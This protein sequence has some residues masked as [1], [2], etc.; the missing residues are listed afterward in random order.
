MNG[1][2]RKFAPVTAAAALV[3]V[4][5]API[6][7]M[8]EAPERFELGTNSSGDACT[9]IRQW[10]IGEGI[11]RAGE[12]PF[13]IT[14]RG[15]SAAESQGYVS[16]PG[17]EIRADQCG[18][19]VTMALKGIGPVEVRRC[20]DAQLGQSAVDVRFKHRGVTYHG[21]ALEVALGPL[22][23]AIRVIAAGGEPPSG[24]GAAK[25]SILLADVPAGPAVS[26]AARATGITAE[27]ALADGIGAL[28]AGRMLDASRVLNDALRAFVDADVATKVDLRLAAGLADS[29]VS[30]FDAARGHF[31]IARQLLDDNPALVNASYKRQQLVT[32]QG[33]DLINQRHW[34]D[35]ID[36]LSKGGSSSRDLV[37]PMTL[38]RLN[39]ESAP[40][41]NS[42]QSS[43]TDAN[44][45]S[46][47]LLDA[48]GNWAISVAELALGHIPQSE[49]ALAR[50]ADSARDSVRFVAPERIVWMRAAIERQ[51]GRI[52]AR[53]GNLSASLANFDCAIAGLQGSRP[54]SEHCVF[55]EARRLTDAAANAPL[56]IE[57]QLERASI[58]S[59]DP[60][61]DRASVLADYGNAIQSLSNQTGIGSVSLGALERYFALLTQAPQGDSRDE[62]YFH[63]MQTIGEPAIAREYAQLQKVVSADAEVAGLLRQRG[64]LERQLIRLRYEI[65]AASGASS[66]D[67]ADLEAERA[68]AGTRLTD[69]NDKLLAANGIGALE[70]QPATIAS[71]RAAL[72]PGEV[73]LKLTALRSALFGIAISRD[74]TMIYQL[75]AGLGEIDKLAGAVLTSARTDDEGVLRPFDVASAQKLFEVVSGP[76]AEMLS[77]AAKLVYDPAGAL[78]QVPAAILVTDKA[79]VDAYAQQTIKSDYSVV[80]FLARRLEIA[81][82]LSP[83]AFLRGRQE[84]GAS[85]APLPFLG[86]G[87]NAP[88]QAIGAGQAERAM[89]F[90]C[91]VTYGAWANAMSN[92]TPISAHEISVAAD[93]LGVANPPEITGA[94]FTDVS[95][96]SGAASQDLAQYQILHFATH[97]LPETQVTVGQCV[98]HLPPSLVTTLASPQRDGPILSDGLLSFDEV[99]RLRLNANLVVLSA[100]ETFAGAS[101]EVARRAGVEDSTPALDGLVRSFIVAN[102]RSVLATFWRV[103]AIAQSDELMAAFYRTGRTASISA[104]LKAAQNIL[105]AQ[106][107]YSHPYYWGAY[108]LVGDG[109]KM[110]LTP[111]R[112]IAA[113]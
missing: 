73:Y 60:G 66:A 80:T 97:G 108:F 63:A 31:A 29:N 105:I 76:A 8:P 88:P 93:A 16:E 30:Q 57:T 44:L 1:I 38:S 84:L 77:G 67:L 36:V 39:Q 106:S 19:P 28:Q 17:A 69:V 87:E 91:A 23:A 56:L 99:A 35:A 49:A 107:R 111:P 61:R 98:M 58:A 32:Y 27:A 52:E 53:K 11:R 95:L 79:S 85:N 21:A 89:P 101:A 48:Q 100:C 68:A 3:L 43:L 83:R 92:S 25:T 40:P 10:T 103:P 37:D 22:E 15:I 12:Q 70:D 62:E 65:T 82:A 74:R 24:R 7:A 104:S 102:A 72:A 64:D 109:S 47:S 33:I 112:T 13:S 94:A 5:L 26:A 4:P 41:K 6:A 75:P 2:V 55:P 45:L 51:K 14:C 18:A 110:M 54:A 81:T 78:R 20:F 9:A 59:R 34:A 50:A 46:R 90:D 113:H 71:V 86:L 42:L 96:V